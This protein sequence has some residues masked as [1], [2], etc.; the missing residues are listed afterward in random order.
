MRESGQAT[1]DRQKREGG[2]LVSKLQKTTSLRREVYHNE[3]FGLLD[4]QGKL[5]RNYLKQSS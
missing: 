4:R 3:K 5:E 1:W 2:W